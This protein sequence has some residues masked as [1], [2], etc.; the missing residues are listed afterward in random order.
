[1]TYHHKV[2]ETGK[3]DYTGLLETIKNEIK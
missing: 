3:Q 1:M 2:N